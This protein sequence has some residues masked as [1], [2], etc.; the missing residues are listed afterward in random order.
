MKIK[1][2][3]YCPGSCQLHDECPFANSAE[4]ELETNPIYAR[5]MNYCPYF[6]THLPKVK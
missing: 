6:F 4:V 1:T 3:Y 5:I 2:S